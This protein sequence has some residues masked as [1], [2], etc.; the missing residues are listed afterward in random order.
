MSVA[1]VAWALEQDIKP[2]A[3][4]LLLVKLAE[5]ADTEAKCWPSLDYL[6]RVVGLKERMVRYHIKALIEKGYVSVE[7][8]GRHPSMFH[9]D[10][11][12]NRLPVIECNELPVNESDKRQSSAP[13][14]EGL[15][16]NGVHFNRQSSADAS[17]LN[18]KEPSGKK[19]PRTPTRAHEEIPPPPAW[20]DK[21]ALP[22][23]K[24]L[25]LTHIAELEAQANRLG[26]DITYQAMACDDWMKNNKRTVKAPYSTLSKWLDKS[27]RMREEQRNGDARSNSSQDQSRPGSNGASGDRTWSE[28]I[29]N[30]G[31]RVV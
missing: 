23:W 26:L 15:T 4:K 25:T 6:C 21:L 9:L 3:R 12:G 20:L 2:P 13:I 27:W 18:R 8:R 24:N 17:L 11:T 14:S 19:P 16:G 22:A 31:R 29:A 5:K 30:R 28:V 10:L 1:A 7:N